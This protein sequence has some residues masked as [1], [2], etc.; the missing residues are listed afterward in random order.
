MVSSLLHPMFSRQ[1]FTYKNKL[2]GFRL[3]KLKEEEVGVAKK[4]EELAPPFYP[5]I[6]LKLLHTLYQCLLNQVTLYL[7]PCL[8]VKMIWSTKIFWWI[9]WHQTLPPL[10]IVVE[11]YNFFFSKIILER[12]QC[13]F[14]YKTSQNSRPDLQ[15]WSYWIY[16]SLW[17]L[18]PYQCSTF[19]FCF[20]HLSCSWWRK[21]YHVYD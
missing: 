6:A 20:F 4:M 18:Q 1:P 17:T 11:I 8:F 5:S 7:C 2:N 9:F 3:Q 12:A 10:F 14:L 19:L 21:V 15:V 16:L 13:K